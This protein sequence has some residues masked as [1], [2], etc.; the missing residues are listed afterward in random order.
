MRADIVYAGNWSGYDVSGDQGEFTSAEAYYTEPRFYHSSCK[1]TSDVTWAGI[2]GYAGR[3][4]QR[5]FPLAQDGTGF[6]VPGLG[7]HQAWWEIF[8]QNAYSV[9]LSGSIGYTFDAF[10]AWHGAEVYS[11]YMHDARTNQH[12]AFR[13]HYNGFSGIS[14]E[15]INERPKI[16]GKLTNLSNY[17]TETISGSQVNGHGIDSYPPG[18]GI[19]QN[20]RH[21]LYMEDTAR[22]VMAQPSGVGSGGRFTIHQDHC[23]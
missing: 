16:N 15:V 21:G 3:G 22:T 1:T 8:P 4:G 10:V 19:A 9:G 2:G 5:R 7:A 11:F 23:D 12:V 14:G 20:G 6:G 17:E 13:E 18:S